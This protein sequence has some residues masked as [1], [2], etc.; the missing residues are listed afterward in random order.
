M[1]YLNYIIHLRYTILVQNPAYG[2][3]SEGTFNVGQPKLHFK[4]QCKT[5]MME[6]SVNVA[7]WDTVV[8][9][10]LRCRAAV[11][12]GARSYKENGVQ[13]AVEARQRRKWSTVDDSTK[14]IFFFCCCQT[15]C[16]SRIGCASP[17][18]RCVLR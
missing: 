16:R 4:D 5:S 9:D 10:R 15:Q 6:L 2:E 13:R 18:P 3:L 17:E 7:N 14:L 8:Q 11:F 1:V 12:T